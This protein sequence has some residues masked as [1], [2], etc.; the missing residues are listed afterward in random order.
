MHNAGLYRAYL[1]SLR[2]RIHGYR[3][4][5]SRSFVRKLA[6]NP[7]IFLYGSGN[8]AACLR[9]VRGNRVRSSPALIACLF[10]SNDPPDVYRFG[11]YT[12]YLQGLRLQL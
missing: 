7:R 10:N 4:R 11:I 1:F 12:L 2:R 5:A 3:Y 6:D 8:A 9:T